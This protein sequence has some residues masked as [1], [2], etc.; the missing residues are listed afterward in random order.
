MP[1]RGKKDT[2]YLTSTCPV[3]TSLT[4]MQSA[5]IYQNI[6]KQAT[7]FALSDPNSHIYCLLQALDLMK[8]KKWM[9]AK[10]TQASMLQESNYF[11][12][13]LKN[14]QEPYIA[15]CRSEFKTMDE[16]ESINIP[17][18]T[19]KID[20]YTSAKTGNI[21]ISVSGKVESTRH[22]DQWLPLILVINITGISITDKGT[23][24]ENKDLLEE[25]NF[26]SE[27]GEGACLENEKE[28]D[29]PTITTIS[30]ETHIEIDPEA[31]I[32]IIRIK[33]IIIK[34][35][36]ILEIEIT[37]MTEMTTAL[38]VVIDLLT[39]H[40]DPPIVLPHQEPVEEPTENGPNII[41]IDALEELQ[42]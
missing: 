34:I 11:E 38:E 19:F 23:Y 30:N 24:L 26:P 33:T 41:T 5:F 39:L 7:T 27:D 1:Y 17:E 18:N 42:Q 35:E 29:N 2:L 9:E 20:K 25:I 6:Y 15:L 40:G 14:W 10:K 37:E 31:E 13:C 8:Q 32:I 21:F 3:D 12:T 22:I 16:K 4:L 36:V 28:T